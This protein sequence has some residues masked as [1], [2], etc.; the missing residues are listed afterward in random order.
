MNRTRRFAAASALLAATMAMPVAGWAQTQAGPATPMPA[1]SQP[2]TTNGTTPHVTTDANGHTPQSASLLQGVEQH[3]R[4]LHRQ[5]KITA[6]EQP[7]WD[8]FAAVMRSNAQAM[9][10]S[11]DQRA[12]QISTMTAVQDMTTYAQLAQQR[13]ED[14]VK[15][16]SAFET[17]YN[18]FSDQQ[19]KDADQLFRQQ[20]EV[21]AEKPAAAKHAS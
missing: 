6:A 13:S 2:A 18:S 16:S 8:Q 4:D 9:S 5:L 21:H 14:L 12:H 20:A 11:L 17:L 15:L 3:I 7:Q 19:K 1:Q 10:D